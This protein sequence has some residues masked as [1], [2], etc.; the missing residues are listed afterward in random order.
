METRGVSGMVD[1][2]PLQGDDLGVLH[3]ENHRI[4]Q[5]LEGDITFS[6][7]Q[8][9][10]GMALHLAANKSGLKRLRYTLNAFSEWLFKNYDCKVLIGVI[11][12]PSVER[13]AR[14]CGYKIMATD[15]NKNMI[16][17]RTR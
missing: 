13:I 3:N 9:G 6:Y 2:I 5:T 11:N 16:Y 10:K 15:S 1:F 4:V 12:R 7:T 8:H 14:K 17:M